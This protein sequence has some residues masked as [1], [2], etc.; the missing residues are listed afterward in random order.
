MLDQVR[1]EIGVSGLNI[2]D[3]AFELGDF[4]PT[5]D[6]GSGRTAQQLAQCIDLPNPRLGTTVGSRTVESTTFKQGLHK[7][8]QNPTIW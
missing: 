6:L 5:I 8:I 4:L 7:L 3:D 2:G 1:T